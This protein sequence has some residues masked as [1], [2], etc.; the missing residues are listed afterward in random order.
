M[1]KREFWESEEGLQLAELWARDGEDDRAI[2]RRM[3]VPERTLLRWKRAG[4][5]LG[6]ALRRAA[7]PRGRWRARCCTRP[8][9]MI[10]R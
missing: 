1:R 7:T 5:P 2:A 4:G 6:E 10:S 3:R 8:P 9:A